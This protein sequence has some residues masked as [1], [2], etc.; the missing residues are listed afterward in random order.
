MCALKG[1]VVHS[2][3]VIV[4]PRW[5]RE[6]SDLEWWD[7]CLNA[8]AILEKDSHAEDQVSLGGEAE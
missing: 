2:T 1:R 5:I 8:F 4:L 3:V 7:S 6:W